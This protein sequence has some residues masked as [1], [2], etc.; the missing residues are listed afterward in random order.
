MYDDPALIE[1]FAYLDVQRNDDYNP[2]LWVPKIR[3]H[4]LASALRAYMNG[5]RYNVIP[6]DLKP[7]LMERAGPSVNADQAILDAIAHVDYRFLPGRFTAP[8]FAQH[9]GL[10]CSYSSYRRNGLHRTLPP[11]L[12]RLGFTS[13]IGTRG[14]EW[15]SRPADGY[16]LPDVDM[17]P[18][19]SRDRKRVANE[20]YMQR[21]M[22]VMVN[23][24]NSLDDLVI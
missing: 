9:A 21:N 7:V 15:W 18:G 19:Q 10:S 2:A 14:G 8:E 13:Q 4:Y 11:L 1:R 12:R 3:K 24:V 20:A 22:P 23:E 6:E 17:K 5:E 16:P